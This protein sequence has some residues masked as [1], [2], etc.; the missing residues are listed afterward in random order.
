VQVPNSSSLNI[1]GAITVE[2]WVKI[3]STG[4]YQDII[5]RES[6]GQSGTG[7]GYELSVTN[8]GKPRLDLYQSPTAYTTVIGNTSISTGVWHHVAGVFDG[9]QMRVYLNGVLDGTLS[10][11]NGPASGTSSLKIGRTSGGNYFNGLIDEARVSN[12]AVYANNFTPQH[13]LTASGTTKGLWKFDSQSPNDSSTN[14]NHGSLQ[15]AIYSDDVPGGGGGGAAGVGPQVQW[16]LSDHLGTPR[17]IFDQ[18]GNLANVRRHDYLPFGEEL[19]GLGLRNTPFLGYFSG[20]GVRQQFTSKERDVETGLD[21]FGARYHSSVQG[22]FTSVDPVLLNP[23]RLA[24]PQRLN[25]Y[26]YSRNSPLVFLDP[27]GEDI[28]VEGG[29]VEQQEAVR[30][31]ITTLRLQSANAETA[32][33]AYD[34]QPGGKGPDL[35]ITIMADADFSQLKGVTGSETLATTSPQGGDAADPTV[36]TGAS[37]IIRSSAVVVKNENNDRNNR[38]ETLV[39]GVLSHEVAGHARDITADPDA[40][41]QRRQQDGN[42]NYETRRNEV[43][44]DRATKR[45]GIERVISGQIDVKGLRRDVRFGGK[46]H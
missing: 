14:G 5:T 21:Y 15:G 30:A 28:I 10:T 35:T 19:V 4:A 6:Y 36:Q 2:A 38:K 45:V 3:N 33:R 16:L 7:G 24:D 31:A 22:R 39:E 17:M 1:T 11:S 44:A 27:N 13:H 9:S 42:L 46:L 12:S 8:L 40:W 26:A 29:T 18:T 23:D 37:V 34:P 25:L 43:T 32:F 41:N 20:D